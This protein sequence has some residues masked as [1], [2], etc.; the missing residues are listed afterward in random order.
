[1]SSLLSLPP[2]PRIVVAYETEKTRRERIDAK[3]EGKLFSQ[4]LEKKTCK[5]TIV[6]VVDIELYAITAVLELTGDFEMR[7]LLDVDV[8]SGD[9][10]KY[11]RCVA[12]VKRHTLRKPLP[13]AE[14]TRICGVPEGVKYDNNILNPTYMS[15]KPV[16]F[17]FKNGDSSEHI[18]ER[19][20][21]LI[22]ALAPA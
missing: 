8:F 21:N 10:A 22:L 15:L 9:A 4:N 17:R 7:C 18:L 3:A 19:Y 20:T 1:M 11:H 16:F 2:S 6:V 14:V 13:L 12:P 5:G